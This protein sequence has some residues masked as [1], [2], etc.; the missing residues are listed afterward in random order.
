MRSLTGR[1]L[2]NSFANALSGASAAVFNLAIPAVLSRHLTQSEFSAWGLSLQI[3]AYVALLGIGLQT[4]VAKQVAYSEEAQARGETLATIR[5]SRSISRACMALGLL[6]S[7]AIAAGCPW[8]FPDIPAQ[9]LGQARWTLVAVGAAAAVQ[10]LSLV[11]MGVFQGLHMNARFATA[12][13]TVR[14]LGVA[15]IVVGVQLDAGMPVLALLLATSLALLTPLM[16]MRLRQH[17][18]G[19]LMAFKTQPLNREARTRLL[20]DCLTLSVWGLSMLAVNTAGMVMVARTAFEHTG[21]YSIAVTAA[22][23]LSGLVGAVISPLLTH[24]AAL[25]ATPE[26]RRE[27]EALL[28]R[29]TCLCACG[30]SGLF[31]IFALIQRPLLTAWVGP[32][33]V[34]TTVLPMLILVGAHALRNVGAPYALMLI[35]TGLNRR[36][37]WTGLAEGLCN[38][39]ATVYLGLRFGVVGVALGTLIGAIVG[40]VGSLLF[41]A[42][43]TA[44]LSPRPLRFAALM[45]LPPLAAA[46]LVF[47]SPF[48]P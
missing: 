30:L 38:L 40:V 21:A 48:R 5:A 44:E 20:R 36:A 16:W 11:P 37:L 12:Q 22:T 46:A 9:V 3:V 26:R 47:L 28:L 6:L 7:M 19:A 4:A 35:A 15:L 25:Y 8:L 17:E 43:R 41:N 1:W 31:L 45:L 24:A 2:G 27:M 23:V 33:L 29:T 13:V 42:P 14:V 39:V 10:L 34:E 32:N 18:A